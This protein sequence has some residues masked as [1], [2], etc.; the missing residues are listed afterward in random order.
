MAGEPVNVRMIRPEDLLVL[1]VTVTN[2][3]VGDDG[4]LHVVDPAT[5]GRIVV[6]LPPQHI[7]EAVFQENETQNEVVAPLPVRSV[8]A[9][10]SRLAFDVPAD[11]PGVPF[12]VAGLLD[13]AALRPALAPNALP[14]DTPTSAG[15][16]RPAEP[17]ADVTAL[18]LAYRMILLARRRARL[19]ASPRAAHR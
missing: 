16:V 4:R 3:A 11:G 8:S 19:A 6:G 13:W 18:E 1:D 7:A 5:P 14:P 12:T 2:L 17:A 9:A 10:P 15:G